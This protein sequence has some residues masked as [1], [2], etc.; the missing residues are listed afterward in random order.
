MRAAS[1]SAETEAAN[2]ADSGD[3]CMP[4]ELKVDN[5]SHE[6]FTIIRLTVQDYPG[7]KPLTQVP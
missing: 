1:A 4:A 2:G 6:A 7:A 3:Y 5:S